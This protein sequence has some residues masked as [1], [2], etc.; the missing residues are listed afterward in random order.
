MNVAQWLEFF[1]L[2]QAHHV[3]AVM[4]LAWQRRPDQTSEER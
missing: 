1:L 4:T 3:Y 2:H